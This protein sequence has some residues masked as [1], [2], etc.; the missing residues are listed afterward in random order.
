VVPE[1]SRLDLTHAVVGLDFSAHAAHA[2]GVACRL[3]DTATAVC[4]YDPRV[5][6]QGGLS[7]AEFGV[8][9]TRNARSHFDTVVRPKLPE[10]EA[11]RFEVLAGVQASDVLLDR[12]GDAVLVVGSRGLNKLATVLLGST[13]ELL[14]GRARGPVFIIRKKGEVLGLL[15]GLFRR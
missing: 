13:A 12:A 2:L 5:A 14:A 10:G 4:Q 1:G 6:T 9:L 15:E 7:Q 8:E 11:P 3:T